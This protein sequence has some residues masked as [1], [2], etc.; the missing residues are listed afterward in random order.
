MMTASATS[1]DSSRWVGV[2]YSEAS[3]ARAAGDEAA[4]AALH[5]AD[6]RLLVVFCS[7]SYDLE[8]LL[9]AIN[10]CSGGVPLIGCS[11]AGQIGPTDPGDASVVV[12]AFGG[13]GFS[14]STAVAQGASGRLREAGADAAACIDA[15]ESRPHR[16][17]MLLSD[18][19][20]GDQQEVIR[21][22]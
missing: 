20:G 8:A 4:G 7:D 22:A 1:A 3:D 14:V 15:L 17:L 12:T 10:E 11:T 5:E 2:G 18:A 19:L 6:A 16:V 13:S 9:G 21:G